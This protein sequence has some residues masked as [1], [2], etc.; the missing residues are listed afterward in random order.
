MAPHEEGF[1]VPFAVQAGKGGNL[2]IKGSA[3]FLPRGAT[4]LCNKEQPIVR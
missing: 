3:M 2:L 4:N 1:G